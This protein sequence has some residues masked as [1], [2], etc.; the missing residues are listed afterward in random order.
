MS[1]CVY[2]PD[3]L[4]ARRHAESARLSRR[5]GSSASFAQRRGRS[6]RLSWWRYRA[7]PGRSRSRVRFVFRKPSDDGRD[8]HLLYGKATGVSRASDSVTES[9][10]MRASA[11]LRPSVST[12]ADAEDDK[13]A[14]H[15][16]ARDPDEHTSLQAEDERANIRLWSRD[17]VP[18]TLARVTF[19]YRSPKDGRS[20]QVERTVKR[21]ATFDELWGEV[22]T[23]VLLRRGG[24][25]CWT[26]C[27]SQSPTAR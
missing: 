5:C 4:A 3:R 21:S 18:Q 13:D 2:L 6:T 15:I 12:R 8:A 1:S 20:V 9:N 16:D 11:S 25:L 19:T 17:K 23:A 22:K 10:M 7:S 27:H 24:A 26:A 14:V